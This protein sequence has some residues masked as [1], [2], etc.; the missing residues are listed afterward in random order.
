M[1]FKDY[2][3]KDNWNNIKTEIK[4]SWSKIRDEDL[5]STKGDQQAISGLIMKKY[6]ENQKVNDAKMLA[7]FQ[8]F[9]D[10]KETKK[11]SLLQMKQ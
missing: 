10:P 1:S 8:K 4:K 5:E 6:N 2:S 3:N 7:I 11:E 9:S